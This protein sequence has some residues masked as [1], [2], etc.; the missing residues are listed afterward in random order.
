MDLGKK[1]KKRWQEKELKKAR[2]SKVQKKTGETKRPK[3]T[4]GGGAKGEGC[5]RRGGPEKGLSQRLR[6]KT[7]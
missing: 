4:A 6:R 2:R 5:M 7:L 1:T 3:E